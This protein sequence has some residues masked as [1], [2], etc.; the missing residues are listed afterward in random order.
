[1]EVEAGGQGGYERYKREPLDDD[2]QANKA[3][4]AKPKAAV[5]SRRCAYQRS[6][7]EISSGMHKGGLSSSARRCSDWSR[8]FK[9]A[10]QVKGLEDFN[11]YARYLFLRKQP[12]PSSPSTCS[13][14]GA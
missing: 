7:G 1:M 11:T 8:E 10:G 9:P 12:W 2:P 3:I 14:Y 6:G 13:V 4:P 5:Y